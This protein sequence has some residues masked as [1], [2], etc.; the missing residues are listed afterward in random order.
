MMVYNLFWGTPKWL[1]GKPQMRDEI[2]ENQLWR[3]QRSTETELFFRVH[4]E[5]HERMLGKQKNKQNQ[6]IGFLKK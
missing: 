2:F 3:L 1:F 4:P 5:R 6:A